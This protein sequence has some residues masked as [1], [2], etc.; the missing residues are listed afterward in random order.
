MV[1][2][3]EGSGCMKRFNT[4]LIVGKFCPLHKGHEYLIETA[5]KSCERVIIISYANPG[6]RGCGVD[7]RRLWLAK[8]YPEAIRLV[9]DDAWLA[10][11]P[12]ANGFDH[13]PHDDE[14]E[15]VH[16]YFSAWLSHTVLGE[17]VDAVFT[18]EDYGDGF[19]RAVADYQFAP[20]QHICVDIARE[21][22]PI[23]GTLV[24]QNLSRF[25]DYLSDVV[26]ASFIK[27]AVFL[28][29]ESTGKTTLAKAVARRLGA[30]FVPEY[31]RE[32]WEQ[33]DGAL[34]FEDMLHIAQTQIERERVLALQSTE[35]LFCDTSPLTTAFYSQSMFG[36]TSPKLE[37]LSNRPYD[38]TFLC[39]PDFR[40]V[41]D[42]TRQGV[43][44][45]ERQHEWYVKALKDKNINFT[46]LKGPLEKRIKA[47][48]NSLEIY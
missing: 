32:I 15:N 25:R 1:I 24:R 3:N 11:N 26:F 30:Q 37:I 34:V 36:K 35:W 22:V 17:T 6:Y 7:K 2:G 21:T 12:H 16:R 45:R 5:L 39:N 20:A 14:P 19:T 44:F 18:S 23:S 4:G 47:V 48:L 29:G 8:L 41:Q 28:G 13:I 43:E 10:A 38:I 42:G 33:K 46:E 31:G 9:V 40:F 27:K